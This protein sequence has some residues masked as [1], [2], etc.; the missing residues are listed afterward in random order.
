MNYIKRLTKFIATTSIALIII[1]TGSS[2]VNADV[3]GTFSTHFSIRPQTTLSEFALINFDIENDLNVTYSMSGMSTTLHTHFG[4]AGLEDV[5][6]S[7]NATLGPF[8]LDTE[9]VFA[10]FP[11]GWLVPFYNTL[12][13]VKKSVTSQLKLGGITLKNLATFED[14][15]AFVSLSAAHAFGD[16]LEVKAQSYHGLTL[17]ART[18]I[19]MEAAPF[20]IKKHFGVSPYSVNPDCATTPKP[21]LIFNFQE[22]QVSNLHVF[23]GL[24][25]D[26]LIRCV[27]ILTCSAIKTVS[28]AKGL[29]PISFSVFSN[30]LLAM[31]FGGAILNLQSPFSSL[32]LVIGSTGDLVSANLLVDFTLNPDTNPS[33]LSI[34]MDFAPGIGLA[35]TDGDGEAA[36]LMLEVERLGLN[37][38]AKGVLAGVPGVHQTV[39][40][41]MT[42]PAGL[43]EFSTGATFATSGLVIADLVITMVF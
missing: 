25:S 5:I 32:K 15:N 4:I 27:D 39:T 41:G 38:F 8:E 19:C 29:I 7:L 23:Y 26:L 12:H 14:T 36:T 2:F 20:S 33:R 17:T 35:D 11:F 13:F 43:F 28:V 31:G 42:A 21:T 24:T 10:R 34:D 30:N 22:F 16:V 1:L 40:L 37:L 9:L 3:T 18:G 6:F